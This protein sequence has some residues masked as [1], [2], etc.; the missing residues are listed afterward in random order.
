MKLIRAFMRFFFHHFYHSLSWTYDFVA[1][2]VSVGRWR[3]WGRTTLP[4]LTGTRVLELGFGP[5]HLQSALNAAG[6]QTIG[7]DESRQMCR[8]AA[9]NLSQKGF[10]LRLTRGQTESLP[11]A[12][13][14][15][16]SLVATFPSEYI[17][18][19]ETLSE[20][21]R[22]LKSGGRLVVALS[23]L[24]GSA[25]L[26]D[27][28]AAW[29]FRVTGQGGMITGEIEDRLKAYFT[30]GRFTVSLIRAE[31]RQSTVILVVA[32]KPANAQTFESTE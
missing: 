8:Q 7:L 3:D 16:D 1:A 26:P 13:D 27:R 17:V 2:V 12:S 28:A 20:A 14:S 11:F 6:F 5:G 21:W 15:F 31:V 18:A 22:V 10:P 30:A 4:H 32:E 9:A 24:P 23:A 19:A 29:L 25:S